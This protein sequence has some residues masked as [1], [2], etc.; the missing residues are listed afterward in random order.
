MPTFKTNYTR[1]TGTL[2]QHKD[3]NDYLFSSV[4]KDKEG[5]RE[6]RHLDAPKEKIILEP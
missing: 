2:V 6:M 3:S 4:A 1:K 5:A